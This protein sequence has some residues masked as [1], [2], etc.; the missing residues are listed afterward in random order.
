MSTRPAGSSTLMPT[1]SPLPINPL[2]NAPLMK[3]G[4]AVKKAAGQSGHRTKERGLNEY[5]ISQELSLRSCRH[6]RVFEERSEGMDLPQLDS[7]IGKYKEIHNKEN[8]PA[9][10]ELGSYPGKDSLLARRYASFKP[11]HLLLAPARSP[12]RPDSSPLSSLRIITPRA[13]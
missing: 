5:P 2:K 11:R 1:Y 9:K 6:A 4:E 12:T 8:P 3:G 13:I 7:F 10:D